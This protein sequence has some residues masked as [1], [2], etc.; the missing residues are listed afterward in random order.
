MRIEIIKMALRKNTLYCIT[1][2][3]ILYIV[4]PLVAYTTLLDYS[5]EQSCRI[6]VFV[7]QALI[8]IFSLLLP[9][10]HFNIWLFSEGWESLAACSNKHQ[11]CSIET[12][13][14]CFVMLLLLLPAWGL[15]CCFYGFLW[16]ELIRL[17]SQCCFVITLYY[18]CAV[19]TKNVALGAIPIVLYVFMC[20][21]VGS[22]GLAQAISMI[23]LY[24]LANYD[25]MPKY[26]V[27][28]VL[29]GLFICIGATLEHISVRR[30]P[31]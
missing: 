27:M 2:L 6:V 18:I 5:R 13:I 30:I 24:E 14:L 15:F 31:E 4:I 21:C 20:I 7:A 29:S 23:E 17:F 16:L 10:A 25:S 12:L 1:Q 22:N 8:P 9:M 3:V 11:S 28:L 19:L 26:Y